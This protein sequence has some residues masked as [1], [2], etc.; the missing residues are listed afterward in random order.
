MMPVRSLK[1][2]N[3]VWGMCD[4]RSFSCSSLEEPMYYCPTNKAAVSHNQH[5]RR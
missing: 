4:H 1:L 5:E 3:N 2:T